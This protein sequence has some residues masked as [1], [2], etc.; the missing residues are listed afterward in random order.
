MKFIIQTAALTVTFF[1]VRFI[2]YKIHPLSDVNT[3]WGAIVVA[4]SFWPGI[5]LGYLAL[6]IQR[7][8]RPNENEPQEVPVAAA[9]CSMLW[10]VYLFRALTLLIHLPVLSNWTQ[11]P[12]ELLVRFFEAL[13]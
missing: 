3:F 13:G 9:I 2:S 11:V 4:F 10:F 12:V 6:H 1:V 5:L 8:A 7:I